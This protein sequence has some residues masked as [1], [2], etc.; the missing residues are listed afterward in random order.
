M[1]TTAV[2]G[3]FSLTRRRTSRPSIPGILRSTMRIDQRP[4]ST[5]FTPA[6]PSG[7]VPIVYPSF[8]SQPE[9]DSRTIS[10]SSTSRIR[11]FFLLM[12]FSDLVDV[13]EEEGPARLAEVRLLGV[14]V[15]KARR[16]RGRHDGGRALEL[17]LA[18][19]ERQDRDEEVCVRQADQARGAARPVRREPQEDAT[20]GMLF[21]PRVVRLVRPSRGD[22]EAH[23]QAEDFLHVSAHACEKFRVDVSRPDPPQGDLAH[24]PAV[25]PATAGAAEAAPPSV[26]RGSR[27][28]IVVPCPALLVTRI[29]PL[30]F[31]TMP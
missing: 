30:C 2:S 26:A 28:V 8:S 3:L 19:D 24:V 27:I 9:R 10:S 7:A 29:E 23:R 16:A 22:V 14:H 12:G 5:A 18:K 25:G 20:G 6:R 11:V 1:I 17:R 31:S 13:L 15:P 21:A 4:S